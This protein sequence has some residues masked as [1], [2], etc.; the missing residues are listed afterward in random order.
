MGPAPP[1]IP[2]APARTT[3]A[4]PLLVVAALAACGALVLG[5]AESG[6]QSVDQ[7][8][9]K[10][11]GAREQAQALGAEIEATSAELASVQAEAIAAAQREAQADAALVER[12]R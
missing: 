5:V 7:L 11:A 12:R 2:H 9:S 4:A 6:A 3:T 10:I 8:N 1:H